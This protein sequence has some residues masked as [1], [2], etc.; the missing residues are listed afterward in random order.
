VIVPGFSLFGIGSSRQ[1]LETL[2]RHVASWGVNTY[3]VSLCTN[4]PGIDHPRNG[5]VLAAFGASLGKPIVYSGFSAGGLA[6]ILATATAT[7]PA[8]FLALD[9]VDA[10]SLARAALEAITVPA[11]ALSGEPSSCNSNVNMLPQY[12]GLP[13]RVLKVNR[14]QHFIFEGATCSGF[15]CFLCNGG[16]D[17]EASAVRALTTAFVLGVSGARPTAIEDWWEVGGA[18]FAELT[19]GG[20]SVS[21]VQ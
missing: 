11:Y 4:G 19:A 6:A 17:K 2:A 21:E 10:N 7:S 9:A 14:A 15:R 16:T 18:G 12:S 20:A 8:A 5:R 13:M 3:T 1:N